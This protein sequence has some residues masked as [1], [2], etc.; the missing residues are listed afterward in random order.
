MPLNHSIKVLIVDDSL[1]FR[2]ALQNSLLKDPGIT[3]VG[4]AGSAA[5]AA[6]KIQELSPDVITMDVEMPDMKGTDFIKKLIPRQPIPVVLVSSLALGIFDALDAGAVD[7]I[8]KPA[9]RT[10]YNVFFTE[11]AAK[12]RVAST[13]K[14]KTK[15]PTP[16]ESL[17]TP[18][19]TANVKGEKIIAIGASTGGTEATLEILKKL[20]ANIPGILV[21]QHMPAGFTKMYADR[22]DRLCAFTV[23]EAQGGERVVPGV[24]YI[25]PGDK[26]MTLAKDTRGY[27]IKCAAGEKVSGHCPSVDVL[28]RSVAETAG[29]DAMGV[30]LTGMGSDGAKGLL[31]MRKQGSFTIGQ[32][33]ASCVVYGM[34][35][36]AF[37]IGAVVRQAPC[38][39]I[40]GI[41]IQH[42]NQAK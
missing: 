1:F 41:I 17:P 14:V 26:H 24:A 15:A 4:T 38:P 6:K 42:L 7:F 34:P 2:T 16:L 28:F 12:I 19:L 23:A 10:D 36:V 31:E 33:K 22:L 30:I 29:S 8:R 13:A 32:D 3:V 25:A 5:E 9:A 11:L 37:D 20:P 40:A 35:M 39:S 18:T 21:V 27:Y